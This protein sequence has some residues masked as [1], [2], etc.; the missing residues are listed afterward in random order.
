M[1][2]FCFFY[3]PLFSSVKEV[4]SPLSPLGSYTCKIF[5]WLKQKC[6]ENKKIP[7][8]SKTIE[9]CSY[10]DD[11]E[12]L[13]LKKSMLKYAITCICSHEKFSLRRWRSNHKIITKNHST[14]D[15]YLKN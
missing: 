6:L 8:A 11:M 1:L 7:K 5:L 15:P 12:H 9:I 13:P 14:D 4:A 3:F 10:V 2:T